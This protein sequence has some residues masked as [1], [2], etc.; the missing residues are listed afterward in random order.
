M[1]KTLKYSFILNTEI[2]WDELMLWCGDNPINSF[3]S[4]QKWILGCWA[5]SK[6][7]A[8]CLQMKTPMDLW[9]KHLRIAGN[10]TNYSSLLSLISPP[11]WPLTLSG[12]PISGLRRPT[13]AR[14]CSP[15]RLR[16]RRLMLPPPPGASPS[17]FARIRPILGMEVCPFLF[18]LKK[19]LNLLTLLIG[20][21]WVFW[22]ECFIRFHC[23]IWDL[24]F[25][26]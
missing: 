4:H 17:R 22:F 12:D 8:L 16:R 24:G 11:R 25:R 15:S 3:L 5:T 10:R 21:S 1:I 20:F 6:M 23:L 9:T 19:M 13:T 18:F 2:A 14:R 7:Q 26:V